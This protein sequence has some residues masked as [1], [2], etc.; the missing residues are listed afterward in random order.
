M[1]HTAQGAMLRLMSIVQTTSFEQI[2]RNITNF[3]NG[4]DV[5]ESN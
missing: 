3:E 1:R 4:L 5:S 2:L